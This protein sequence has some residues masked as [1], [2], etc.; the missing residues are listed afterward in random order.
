VKQSKNKVPTDGK[1]PPF[2]TLPA[3]SK[4]TIKTY[5][6]MKKINAI[7]MMTAALLGA[8][9]CSDDNDEE[10]VNLANEVAGE[11]TG[12]TSASC[13]YF[14]G[15]I[16]PDQKVNI[17]A[18]NANEVTVQY[19]STTWGTFTVEGAQ[20][21]GSNANYTL[22]GTGTASMGHAGS[23]AKDYE[24]TVSGTVISGEVNL[25]FNCPAVMG[26]LTINFAQG[27]APTE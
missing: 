24:C 7:L 6:I 8:A 3:K 22:A 9:S 16:S 20:V 26:G 11:Y 19:T 13:A 12:Y 15:T 14:T 23:E 27:D 1:T 17:T 2:G 4:Q 18:D 5:Y 25:T 21:S 10:A